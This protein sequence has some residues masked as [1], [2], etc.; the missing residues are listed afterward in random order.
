M[1]LSAYAASIALLAGCVTNP[2]TIDFTPTIPKTSVILP[3]NPTEYDYQ[4]AIITIGTE[5]NACY[6][7]LE[8]AESFY[9]RR[10]GRWYQ[11]WRFR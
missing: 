5:R 4:E 2:D 8:R 11:F 6:D 7:D 3:N 1:K 9:K 10:N